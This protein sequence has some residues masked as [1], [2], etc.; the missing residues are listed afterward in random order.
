MQRN[1]EKTDE[2]YKR[3][4]KAIPKDATLE[5]MMYA[6]L[7][8]LYDILDYE[9]LTNEQRWTVA[10]TLSQ[11]IENFAKCINAVYRNNEKKN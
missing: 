1:C 2:L 7:S 3:L 6:T 10:K 11:R 9:E 8:L 4:R 5:D